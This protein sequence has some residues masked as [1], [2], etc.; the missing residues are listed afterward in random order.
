MQARSQAR[1]DATEQL[2]QGILAGAL[3]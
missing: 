2:A 1:T 3:S